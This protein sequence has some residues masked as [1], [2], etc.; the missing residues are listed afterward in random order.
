ME[1]IRR[2]VLSLCLAIAVTTSSQ[3]AETAP[4][5]L[6]KSA[7]TDFAAALRQHRAEGESPTRFSGLLETKVLPLF[8]FSRMAQ[9]ATGRNWR[10][11]SPAQQEALTA[12]FKA[13]LVGTYAAAL[14]GYRDQPIAYKPVRMLAGDTDVTVRSEVKQGGGTLKIDYDMVK[15]EAG[16]KVY[17][18]KLQGV[19][20]V[21]AYRGGFAAKV[22]DAGVDGL[23]HA[24]AE[25]NRLNQAAS[26][27]VTA[28][29]A[30][31]G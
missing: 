22:R 1:T 26:R 16:W 4:D 8:D 15:T 2:A 12:E 28:A 23:I 24:L 20:L 30:A 25:K 13:L 29:V 11:A 14:A 9:L 3:A 17:D 31:G 7:T 19:S 27:P 6:L 21:T 18:V 10:L 5:A